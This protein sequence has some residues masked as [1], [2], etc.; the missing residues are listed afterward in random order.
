MR[1]YFQ[2]QGLPRPAMYNNITFLFVNALLNWVFV[3]G[4][5]FRYLFGWKGLGF[6]GAAISLSIS[7]TMQGV[8]YFFY[9]FVYKKYHLN[10]W[11]EAGLSL[12]HHTWDRTKEFMTQSLPN[13]GTLLFSVIS[14]QATTVLVGRL[15]ERA[16]AASSA[17]STV[18]M[19]WSGT[20]GA[21]TCTISGVRVG[22]HLGRGDGA[23]A[24]K[25][26]WM[27]NHFISI[28][29][30]AVAILFVPLRSSIL[31]IA[32]DDMDVISLSI[33]LIPAMLVSTW[34][35]LLVGNITSGVFSGMGRPIIATIL[36]FGFELPMSIGGVAIYILLFHGNLMGVYWWNAISGAI[37]VVVVLAVLFA[38]DWNHWA[39][40]AQR[41]QEANSSSTATDNNEASDDGPGAAPAEEQAPLVE[42]A[43]PQQDE[44]GDVPAGEEAP[45]VV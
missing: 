23:A 29:M 17:L 31:N 10:S 20:L 8:V 5:P 4:G 9:M 28:V 22:Y 40:E 16:I 24:Q 39:L 34:L 45:T 21:T 37:E 43:D 42:N 36:S 13:L 25:T 27:V 11:P 38:S 6:I 32:T 1:F 15:G 14:S 18:S 35:N 41:R 26:A 19:P 7:R 33:K 44:A 2:A 12:T 30:V 3:F